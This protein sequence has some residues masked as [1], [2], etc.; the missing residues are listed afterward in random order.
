MVF[1]TADLPQNG[2]IRYRAAHIGITDY[3]TRGDREAL[4]I[5]IVIPMVRPIL[6][7]IVVPIVWKQIQQIDMENYGKDVGRDIRL[8]PYLLVFVA[9]VVAPGGHSVYCSVERSM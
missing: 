8:Y 1:R 3:L 2:D 9:R 4:V 5:S 6:G 7:R